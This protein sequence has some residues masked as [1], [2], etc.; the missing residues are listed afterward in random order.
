M[1]A[2]IQRVMKAEILRSVGG[3]EPLYELTHKY[4]E[5]S[6]SPM[7][8]KK[9]MRNRTVIKEEMKDAKFEE[10]SAE[11]VSLSDGEEGSDLPGDEGSE[12]SDGKDG[13]GSE[14][15]P[16]KKKRKKK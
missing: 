9:Q 2:D 10:V 5:G 3:P 12:N 14:F 8:K 7:W 11:S 4:A 13:R 15:G 1:E 16:G 6:D